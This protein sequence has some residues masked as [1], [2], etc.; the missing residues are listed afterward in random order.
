MADSL[1]DFWYGVGHNRAHGMTNMLLVRSKGWQSCKVLC[2]CGMCLRASCA[3][4]LM[5][6]QAGT[7][8]GLMPSVL[9]HFALGVQPVAV[10][11]PV[12]WQLHVQYQAHTLA[13]APTLPFKCRRRTTGFALTTLGGTV[14]VSVFAGGRLLHSAGPMTKPPISGYGC[15]LSMWLVCHKD[16]KLQVQTPTFF[17]S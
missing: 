17:L 1:A 9:A 2:A 11:Q 16:V 10:S 7:L 15:G 4:V 13:I 5:A 12:E 6:W 14:E 8:L 3:L